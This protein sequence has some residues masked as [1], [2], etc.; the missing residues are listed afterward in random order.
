MSNVS[1]TPTIQ[2]R[3]EYSENIISPNSSYNTDLTWDIISG[4]GTITNSSENKYAGAKSL[5]VEW[6]NMNSPLE[7]KT[8]TDTFTAAKT[9]K[10]V[11]S[12]HI[13]EANNNQTM[14]CGLAYDLK[15]FKNGSYLFDINFN[16]EALDDNVSALKN[17][18]CRSFTI[19]LNQGDVMTWHYKLKNGQTLLGSVIHFIDG[20]KIELDDR[21][22]YG[23]P[24]YYLPPNE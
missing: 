10:Y 23:M 21:N 19:G 14:P 20:L 13:F 24:T 9:G 3:C 12:H 17:W 22:L 16:N 15:I 7:F 2:K 6:L 8:D 18:N 1:G 4:S 5:K 11:F